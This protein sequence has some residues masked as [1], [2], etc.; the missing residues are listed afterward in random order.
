LIEREG[1]L[2]PFEIKLTKTLSLEYARP[3]ERFKRLFSRLKIGKS[4][5]ISLSDEEFSL[6]RDLSAQSMHGYLRWLQDI[7]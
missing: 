1:L 3:I 2:Y 7:S 6:T 5:I 4:R